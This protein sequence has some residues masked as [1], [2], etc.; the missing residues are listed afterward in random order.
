MKRGD[1]GFTL[2]EFAISNLTIMVMLG[3]TF[4]LLSMVFTAN[5][6]TAEMMQTQQNIRV[7]MNTIARDITMAGT[8]LPN[9]GIAVPSGS[10]FE[11]L[12]RPG[13][14]DV[15]ATPNDTIAL[16]APGN[17]AGVTVNGFKTDALTITAMNQDSPTWNVVDNSIN[18][19]GTQANFIQNIRTGAMQLLQNDLLVLTNANGSVFGCVTSVSMTTDRA[20]FADMDSMNVNQPP[21]GAGNIASLANGDGS[22]PPTTATKINIITYYIS[23]AVA[24]HPRLMRAVNADTPQVIVEDIE[25]LQFSFDLFDVTND[26]T[27]ANQDSTASANQIRSVYVS[28]SG[29]SPQVMTRSNKYYRFSLASKVNVRNATFRNRYT[30]T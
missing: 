30:G 12:T 16:I 6:S 15:M 13:V 25:N 28:I 21:A 10:N 18:A 29:R 24:A 8:G 3:A 14:G 1:S 17:E 20:F 26:S 11:Q 22:Y 2:I 23:A 9:G 4:T 5:R 7:A 27:T 19:A